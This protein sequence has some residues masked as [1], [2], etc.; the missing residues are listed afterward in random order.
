MMNNV[1]V[2]LN[3]SQF[4]TIILSTDMMY[5]STKELLNIKQ[6]CKNL[7]GAIPMHTRSVS[8]WFAC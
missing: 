6:Q 1:D 8:K 2:S 5:Y 4:N 3:N 7:I